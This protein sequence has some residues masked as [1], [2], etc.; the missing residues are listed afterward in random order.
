[1]QVFVKRERHK[2]RKKGRIV[3]QKVVIYTIDTNDF[4]LVTLNTAFSIIP[5]WNYTIL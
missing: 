3:Q 2:E 5:I 4:G 1:M